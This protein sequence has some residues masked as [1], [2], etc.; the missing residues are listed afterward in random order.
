MQLKIDRL[1]NM[2]MS[3]STG[4]QITPALNNE[5]FEIRGFIFDTFDQT[6][7]PS[8][9]HSCANLE[10]FR[11]EMQS[12]Y[13][14]YQERRDFIRS[15]LSSLT[16]NDSTSLI[17]DIENISKTVVPNIID[18]FPGD[19]KEKAKEMGEAYIYLYCIENSLRLFIE[20]ILTQE[21]GIDFFGKILTP[22]SL[23]ATIESRKRQEGKS[24]WLP[25]RGDSNLFYLDFKEL[26]TIIVNNWDNFK[27]Y[28]PD[29]AWITT[30]INE[31]GE[32]RNLI[33]HNS[34]I[35]NSE[36]DLIRLYFNNILKQIGSI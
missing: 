19:I 10:E 6:R 15:S 16:L 14:H 18:I 13:K 2:L 32:C 20:K 3:A 1:K 24:K 11:L 8:F 36:K 25:L 28:F 27:K 30:K 31:L 34:W 26:G 5:Y 35:G 22:T 4:G 21:Y 33:A 12:K 29:Q 23:K 9:L 7:I 17:G